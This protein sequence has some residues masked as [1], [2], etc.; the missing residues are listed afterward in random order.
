M[1]NDAEWPIPGAH[2]A[3]EAT[4]DSAPH[5]KLPKKNEKEI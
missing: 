3:I 5:G 1:R 4:L 2:M